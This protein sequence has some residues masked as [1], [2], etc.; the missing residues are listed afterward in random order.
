MHP[1]F[2][3]WPPGCGMPASRLWP[4]VVAAFAI[5][6][7]DGL[8]SPPSEPS[9][10]LFV[11]RAG[12]I[13]ETNYN[14]FSLRVLI[15]PFMDAFLTGTGKSGSCVRN[16][17]RKEFS[18]LILMACLLHRN[19]SWSQSNDT[20]HN[21]LLIR[22][23]TPGTSNP[24]P[25]FPSTARMCLLSFCTCQAPKAPNGLP[26][27]ILKHFAH[28]LVD[29]LMHQIKQVRLRYSVN[30]PDHWTT[31]W[32]HLLTKPNKSP[33]KPQALRPICLQHPVNKLLA[34]SQCRQIILQTFDRLRR[35]RDT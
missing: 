25:D 26:A 31:G 24:S 1:R 18:S 11:N 29:P 28:D 8:I 6:L 7:S 12:K 21:C 27:L 9:I 30:L 2:P 32:I 15:L 35:Q 33:S 14:T 10:K 17:D 23:L 16:K 5:S 20:I 3:P 13:R 4:F 19:R 22:S 34:G